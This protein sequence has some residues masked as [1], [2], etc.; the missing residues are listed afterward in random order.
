MRA[1]QSILAVISASYHSY[2]LFR[3]EALSIRGCA[4]AF[5]HASAIGLGHLPA[6]SRISISYGNRVRLG[7]IHH[8]SSRTFPLLVAGGTSESRAESWCGHELFNTVTTDWVQDHLDDPEVC[9]LWMMDKTVTCASNSCHKQ[10][11]LVVDI[12]HCVTINES[13]KYYV[14]N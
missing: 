13:S 10:G 1:G 8:Y 5:V 4:T 2:P 7:D 6:I 11:V 14:L 3:Q 9:N 12:L